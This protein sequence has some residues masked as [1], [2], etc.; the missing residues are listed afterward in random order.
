ML[1]VAY[2]TVANILHNI[3]KPIMESV[4][5]DHENQNGFIWQRGCLVSMFTLKQLILKRV[6]HG[7]N[8]GATLGSFISARSSSKACIPP[9]S[10]AQISKGLIYSRRYLKSN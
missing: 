1:E 4:R 2:K 9:Q 6:E 7:H 3:L 8:S 10:L 5:L